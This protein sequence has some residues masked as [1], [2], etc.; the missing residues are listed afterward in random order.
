MN[1]DAESKRGGV[2]ARVYCQVLEEHLPTILDADSIFMHDNARIH[3]A[4]MTQQWLE[5]NAIEVME[6]PPYS[7]D[8][9][10]IENLWFL[11][12]E[13]IYKLRP[14]LLTMKGERE[15]LR[16]LIETAPRAWNSIRDIILNQL[17]DTME[18]RVEAVYKADG[19]YTRY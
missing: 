7:P 17:S 5:D 16:V 2:T 1:G 19:L 10:P 4:K 6:W 12:K 8:L 15:V 3:T 13:A 9:N 14:D 11:L 18:H